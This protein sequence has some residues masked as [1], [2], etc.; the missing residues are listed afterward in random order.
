VSIPDRESHIKIKSISR[1]ELIDIQT[2]VKNE[3]VRLKTTIQAVKDFMKEKRFNVRAFSKYL[4]GIES[5]VKK[6]KE[7]LIVLKVN[8][9]NDQES[10][11][12]EPNYEITEIDEKKY[13]IYREEYLH[14]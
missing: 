1:E 7:E 6:D 13:K 2:Q 14:G 3:Q 11:I 5:W 9:G 10:A 12:T 8:R 4:R